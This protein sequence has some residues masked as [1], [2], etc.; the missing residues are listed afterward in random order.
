M[1]QKGRKICFEGSVKNRHVDRLVWNHNTLT[2]PVTLDPL[3]CKN[4]LKHLNGTNNKI[5]NNL[6]YNKTFTLLEDHYFQARLE[7]F[8]TLFTVYKLNKMYT[9][10]FTVMSADKD[11]IYDPN[12]NP[13]HNCPAHHQFEVNPVSWRLEVSELELTC[14]DTENVKIIDEHTLPCYFADGFCK[15]TTKTPFTL[16]WFSD[17]FCLIFTLQDF[18][19]Q[20][21]KIQDRYWIETDSFV[22][23]SHSFKREAASGVKGTIHPHVH[24]PHT[25]NPNNPSLSPFEVFPNAQALRG[26]TDPLYSTQYSDFIVTY[27]DGFNLHTGQPNPQSMINELNSGEFV[28]DNSNNKF[29]FP[30]SNVSNNFATKDYDAH[31]NTKFVYTINHVFRSMTVQELNTLHTICELERNHLFTIL[32][33]SVQNLQ[34]AGFLLTANL[35]PFFIC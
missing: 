3:E 29:I 1:C 25:Q 7:R 28:R 13:Y 34:L 20:M 5:L 17:G 26:K 9:C 14:D 32:V 12:K 30:A 4:F 31:I 19:G 21:T 35:Q 33:K 22:H 24:A 15:P 2:L 27:T 16:V 8:Q 23:S 11:W 10:T 18:I 6:L